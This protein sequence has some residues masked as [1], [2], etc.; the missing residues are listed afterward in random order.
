MAHNNEAPDRATAARALIELAGEG[1][2]R[3]T[4]LGDDALW[5]IA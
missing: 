1:A 2:V 4:P 5:Q 3:R